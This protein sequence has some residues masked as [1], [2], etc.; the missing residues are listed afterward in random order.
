[1]RI[2]IQAHEELGLPRSSDSFVTWF[3]VD[4][5]PSEVADGTAPVVAKADVALFQ[6]GRAAA[7]KVAIRDALEQDE[8]CA[9]DLDFYF[10]GREPKAEAAPG[11]R[12]DVL[13]FR[14]MQV[15][16]GWTGRGIELAVVTRVCDVLGSGC[17]VVIAAY[18]DS[19]AARS[20]RD[21]GF[22]VLREP[23][24]DPHHE[25]EQGYLQASLSSR[26]MLVANYGGARFSAL[27]PLE[28]VPQPE[29]PHSAL[30]PNAVAGCASTSPHPPISEAERSRSGK[31]F[32]SVCEQA[33]GPKPLIAILHPIDAEAVESMAATLD[34]R[35]WRY[36]AKPSAHFQPG[37]HERSM[38]ARTC[39]PRC[40]GALAER[41]S[42]S[43]DARHPSE[44]SIRGSRPTGPD[45]AAP[46]SSHSRDTNN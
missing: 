28:D 19:E 34:L 37:E 30:V 29:A 24:A 17:A 13:Y 10:G 1:M 40:M 8:D 41:Y 36:P 33:L 18:L 25:D 9:K 32:C 2:T 35:H 4:I 16:E 42:L 12:T 20:Y 31:R 3:T 11:C 21:L 15:R 7:A 44:E 27:P 23:Y 38:V 45:P 26:R 6:V 22:E 14:P 43:F 5:I 46:P 39:S